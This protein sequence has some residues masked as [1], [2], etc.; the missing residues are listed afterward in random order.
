MK[1]L[2]ILVFLLAY[3]HLPYMHKTQSK[4]KKLLDE[5]SVTR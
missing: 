4:A 2:A 1:K 3:L 5:V